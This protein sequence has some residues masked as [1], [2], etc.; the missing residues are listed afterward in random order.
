M[1]GFSEKQ[2]PTGICSSRALSYILA[3]MG[4]GRLGTE[5]AKTLEVAVHNESSSNFEGLL[6][7]VGDGCA[8]RITALCLRGQKV[9]C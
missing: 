3:L 1:G 4:L 6:T 7:V 9:A 2:R 8:M 5:L